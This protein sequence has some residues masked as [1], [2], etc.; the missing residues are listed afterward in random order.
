MA[1]GQGFVIP[2]NPPS[3]MIRLYLV[4]HGETIE[5]ASHILQGQSE[6]H[7]SDVGI[8]QAREVAEKLKATTF[9]LVI[10]SDLTRARRTAEIINEF[11]HLPL[12]TSPLLRE[13]DWGEFTGKKISEIRVRPEEFPPSVENPQQ[14]QQRARQFLNFL[15][16]HYEGKTV[17]AVG[18]GYFNRCILAEIQHVTPHSVPRVENCEVRI[19]EIHATQLAQLNSSPTADELSEK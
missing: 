14:L 8:S 12:F 13:R 6:G 4:R 17:L 2:N 9:D 1:H 3:A 15:F 19:V 5:N 11:H 16:E 10:S 7:L 18:H